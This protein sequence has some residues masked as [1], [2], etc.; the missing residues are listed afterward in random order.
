MTKNTS[1]TDSAAPNQNDA[2]AA[3]DTLME[4][5]SQALV[6]MDYLACESD[7]LAAL[8]KA[9]EAN[10][11]MLYA[12]ILLPLQ[13]SRRQRR[14]T[15]AEG[16]VM[17]GCD[18]TQAALDIITSQGPGCVVLTHPITQAQAK[19]FAS[20]LLQRKLFVALLYANNHS[21]DQTW[22]I[23]ALDG[24]AVS[25]ATDAPPANW[26]GNVLDQNNTPP[27]APSQSNGDS[28]ANAPT[29][30]IAPQPSDWF[31]DATEKLGDAAIAWVSAPLG[32]RERVEQLEACLGVVSDHEFL[33]QRLADAARA[34][35]LSAR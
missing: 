7:C 23:T 6:R 28:K 22:V 5:A 9:K 34:L 15:A 2:T 16:W 30:G 32:T 33:H 17:L 3:I 14:I 11:W 13:E 24:P 31:I 27:A 12:R 8:G 21:V 19:D 10:Q 35:A 1:P 18:S 29:K 20:N 26:I 4:R 25:V